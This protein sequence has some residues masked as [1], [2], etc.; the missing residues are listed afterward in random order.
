[1]DKSAN[2]QLT[3]TIFNF[4]GITVLLIIS[5]YLLII[6]RTVLQPLVTAIVLWYIIVRLAA[7]IQQPSRKV[8]PMPYGLALFVAFVMTGG[9]VYWFFLSLGYSINNIVT[10]A[11]AYQ[12]ILK[13][14]LDYIN[15]F[16]GGRLNTKDMLGYVNFP[17]VFSGVAVMLSN[18]AADLALISI[19]LLFIFLEYHTFDKKLKAMCHSQSQ[20]EKLV[21][22]LTQIN[23]DISKYLKVKTAVSALTGFCS[24]LIL[25][26]FGVNNAE[27]WALFIFIL[28]FIPTVGAIVA[29]I[30]TLIAAAVQATSIVEFMILT[31]VLV[32]VQLV[33]G[34]YVEPRSMGAYLNL[35]PMVI[36][37]SLAFW[38]K[39]WGI[40]GML[41]C[42]PMMAIFTIIF[43]NF[44]KTRPI[45]VFL[46]AKGDI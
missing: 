41:L 6:G 35:S 14:W 30:I 25:L 12:Q 28:N 23:Y 15:H 32:S 22:T 24:Y 20:Y 38:G 40:L 37:F 5:V 10:E 11:G 4:L 34:N 33:I 17:T 19:Y 18:L 1:M 26:A 13:D 44:K 21:S 31:G 36:L 29:V 46:S 42:V 45:A 8:R 16:F 9:M 43:A 2:S 7:F 3:I 27:F 39:I